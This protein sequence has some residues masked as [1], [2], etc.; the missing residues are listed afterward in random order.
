[1]N[2]DRTKI[3]AELEGRLHF[4]K[5]LT[6]LLADFVTIFKTNKQTKTNNSPLPS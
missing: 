4:E 2:S 6:E 5:L 3:T 1:M